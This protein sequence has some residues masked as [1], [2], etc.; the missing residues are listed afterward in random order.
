VW[1]RTVR[2]EHELKVGAVPDQVWA[3]ARGPAALSAMPGWFAFGVPAEA[4]GTDRLCCLIITDPTVACAVVDVRQEIEGQMICWQ[5]RGTRPVGK[6]AFTIGILPRPGGS[7]V[8][9]SVSNVVLRPDVASSETFWRTKIRAWARSLREI[10]EGR[11][12]WPGTGMPAGMQEKCSTLRPLKK[13]VQ[14]SA[15]ALI[16]APAAV[17]WEG[18]YAPGL[19]VDP[20]QLACAGRVPGTPTGMTGEM[21]Y[22]VCHREDGRLTAHVT[23]AT[24]L[25]E[26][27]SAVT[28]TIA[29]HI[30]V[31]YLVTPVADGTR[32]ELVCRW[33][34]RMEKSAGKNV[35]PAIA[36]SLEK[37]VEK[38]K[39]LIEEQASGCA[40][41][42]GQD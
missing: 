31:S 30:E 12:A 26:G 27:V 41:E 36:I 16:Q 20:A 2:V 29:R 38:Y 19:L 25:V 3:L 39:A 10:A 1:D 6:Q 4:T 5:T 21:Q 14:A 7:T 24:E 13:P 18:V 40:L 11:A 28:R 37:T 22:E 33:P 23:V 34:A 32:L 8:R 15:A 42:G 9:L 17:V 35:A